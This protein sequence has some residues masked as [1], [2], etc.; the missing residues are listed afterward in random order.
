M[1]VVTRGTHNAR[2]LYMA[3][4]ASASEGEYGDISSDV[5]LSGSESDWQKT[6]KPTD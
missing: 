1:R 2:P 4:G 5:S 3:S 6:L